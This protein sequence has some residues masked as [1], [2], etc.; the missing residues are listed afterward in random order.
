M[1]VSILAE[2]LSSSLGVDLSMSS[3]LPARQDGLTR[4]DLGPLNDLSEGRLPR[5]AYRTWDNAQSAMSATSARQ[6]ELTK[7]NLRD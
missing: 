2:D 3:A 4:A 5:D 1:L 7:Y 6:A